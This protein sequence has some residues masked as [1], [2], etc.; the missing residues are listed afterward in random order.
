MKL[1]ELNDGTAVG[2][3][4]VFDT[5][6]IFDSMIISESMFGELPTI[7][8]SIQTDSVEVQLNDSISGYLVYPNQ[9]K[10]SFVGYIY[11]LN[12]YQSRLI[13]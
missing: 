12:Y 13:L 10:T 11:K 5:G 4:K 3:T 2:L 9:L 8:L 1:I 6:Y 7:D